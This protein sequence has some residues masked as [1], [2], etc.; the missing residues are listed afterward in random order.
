MKYLARN[1]HTDI[2]LKIDSAGLIDYHEGESPDERMVAY[3][4]KRGYKLDSTA[5]KFDPETDFAKFDLIIT[6]DNDIFNSVND[7]DR[8][9]IY[10]D[11][12]RK[13]T[14]FSQKYDV[15][16]IPDPYYGSSENFNFV[17]DVL[18]DSCSGLI[19]KLM[20]NDR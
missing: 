1:N 20:K 2:K 18:E 16:E 8:R 6:M 19:E 14:D 13:M 11:K 5:R 9:G 4:E 10:R 3:A 15:E 7:L 12:I 17:L